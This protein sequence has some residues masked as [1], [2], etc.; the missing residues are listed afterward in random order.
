MVCV[1][2]ESLGEAGGRSVASGGSQEKGELVCELPRCWLRDVPKKWAWALQVPCPSR[3]GPCHT[4]LAPVSP[5]P[6]WHCCSGQGLPC[7]ATPLAPG[8]HTA[9][10]LLLRVEQ[11]CLSSSGA[12]C[13]LGHLSSCVLCPVSCSLQ[14]GDSLADGGSM[15]DFVSVKSYS[16]VSLDISML[17]SLGRLCRHTPWGEVSLLPCLHTA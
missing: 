4:P 9:W 8:L 3:C 1:V 11:Q 12:H 5:E 14:A 17:G 7:E 13:S 2:G 16:D 15:L 10:S 6:A